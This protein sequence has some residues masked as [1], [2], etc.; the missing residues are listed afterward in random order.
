LL[1]AQHY[2]DEFEYASNKLRTDKD[3][4]ARV[5]AVNPTLLKELPTPELAHDFDLAVIAL[6]GPTSTADATPSTSS[7]A[8]QRQ[9]RDLIGLYD[10]NDPDDFGFLTKLAVHV[11]EQVASHE[12]FVS[13]ILGGMTATAA[14]EKHN[15]SMDG[16]QLAPSLFAM[17]N[18]GDETSMVYKKLLAE[19]TGVPMGNEIHV[20]R[21]A[22]A[23]LV[24]WGY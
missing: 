15:V 9:R 10:M 18:Q 17:L 16:F 12:R 8:V 21:R 24:R 3:F 23:N 5:L 1:I 19:F 7:T 2:P 4:L 14:G 11:H 22:S 6:G 20:L 13:L